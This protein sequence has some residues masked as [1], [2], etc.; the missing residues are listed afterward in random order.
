MVTKRKRNQMLT[1]PLDL[2]I[3]DEKPSASDQGATSDALQLE[4]LEQGYPVWTIPNFFSLAECQQWI[5]FCE[6]S[7]GLTYTAHSAT[8][9]TAHRK[10]F[11]MQDEHNI[12][13][14][15]KLYQRLESSGIVDQLKNALKPSVR[16][17]VPKKY[18]NPT[19]FNPNLRLYKY[20]GGH[21]FGKHIDESNIVENMGRTEITVLVYLSE[22]K[23]GA[24]RFFPPF[25]KRSFSF[26]PVPGTMLL[27]VH[28]EDCLEHEADPVL[29]GTKY[30][31]RTDVVFS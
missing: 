11:R 19:G 22:C 15:E 31:L 9:Y 27:H 26:H 13:L 24:T 5:K 30:V 10:C 18:K 12:E 17:R 1:F 8:M 14:A 21:S 23:G 25:S 3:S 4:S 29:G 16:N 20:C 2:V 28:G 7:G 6:D